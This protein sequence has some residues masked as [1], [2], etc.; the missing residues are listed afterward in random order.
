MITATD[1]AA[2]ARTPGGNDWYGL[3]L[4][5]GPPP[6]PP[7]DRASGVPPWVDSCAM[8]A[9]AL[10]PGRPHTSRHTA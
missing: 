2:A 1:H 10:P 7:P 9:S 4:P 3:R 6:D 5:P 8:P